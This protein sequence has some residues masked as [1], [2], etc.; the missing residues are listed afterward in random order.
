[1]VKNRVL[2]LAA[3]GLF[4]L[5]IIAHAQAVGSVEYLLQ[6]ARTYLAEGKKSSAESYA[7]EALA[8]DPRNAEAL[9]VLRS[10]S[11]RDAAMSTTPAR[12]RP[13]TTQIGSST[14]LLDYAKH[15]MRTGS[16]AGAADYA[17][18]ALRV[19]PAS[20]E[21]RQILALAKGRAAKGGGG[22]ICQ[23]RFSTCWAGAQTYTPGGGYKADN[24]RRQQCFVQR[25]LCEARAR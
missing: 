9:A 19:D 17:E 15:H 16:W 20:V 12:P 24:P 22:S 1:M 2:I 14:Y 23:A 6:Y 8:L 18:Q 4:T 21:A 13:N 5:P 11:Q 25:N 10:T 7:K 3:G